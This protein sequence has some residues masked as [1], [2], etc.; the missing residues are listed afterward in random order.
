MIGQTLG[1]Y[2]LTA[3]LGAGGMGEV[4][5]A[6]DLRLGRDVALKLLPSTMAADP[7]ML[8]RFGQEARALAALDHPNIV[9]V[10]SVENAGGLHFL[11][12]GLV[13]GQTLDRLIPPDGLP[14]TKLLDLA[15]PL[16]EALA[17]AHARGIVHRDVKPGNVMVTTDGGLK[18]LDFGLSK[19]VS[20]ES[21]ARETGR[22]G[23]ET[24]AHTTPGTLLGTMPYMS[25]EQA[26]CLAV[27]ARSDIFSLG[28]VLYEMATGRRPFRGASAAALV[29]SILKDVPDSI[30]TQRKD[31]PAKF[32]TCVMHCLN[33]DRERRVQSLDEVRSILGSLRGVPE[34]VPVE[35]RRS[36][37]T[38]RPR[39]ENERSVAVLPFVNHSADA[40]D[41]YFS[42]GITEEI[43]NA[44]MQIDGLRVAARTSSFAFKGSGKDLRS[45][46]ETLR[47]RNVLEGSVRRSG[48]RLRVTAQLVDTESG[49]HLWS[50]R[51]D[52]ELDDVF[53]IQ[54]EIASAIASKLEVTL[55]GPSQKPS[56]RG[57]SNLEAFD[58]YLRGLAL[59]NRRG[60]DLYQAIEC[61]EK[62]IALDPG[63]ADALA[64]MA[65]GHRLLATYGFERAPTAMPRARA[66]AERAL[67]LD[68]NHA[69]ALATLADIAGQYDRDPTKAFEY[70]DRALVLQNG[71]TRAR[72]ERAVWGVFVVQGEP[73]DAVA[74][75]RR[76][77]DA[78]PLNVW[79]M[80]MLTL[81]LGFAGRPG[82]GLEVA[83]QALETDP[84]SYLCQYAA[85]QSSIWAED[86]DAAIDRAASNLQPSGRHP[87]IL[88][89][90]GVAHAACG[91][92]ELADAVLA[93]LQAR[94]RLEYVQ[95]FWLAYLASVLGRPE[96]AVAWA[97]RAIEEY[98]PMALFVTRW[99]G[100]TETLRVH[101]DYPTLTRAL[102]ITVD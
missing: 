100:L 24:L 30:A 84:G 54:D 41:E 65:D 61:F 6:H 64:W 58:L 57:T 74:E 82:E 69:E 68:P 66:A 11:T 55:G 93:E 53:E 14:W 35:V 7:G 87:W 89:T 70:W 96:E 20:P 79:A 83:M 44:L 62:A 16:V 8:E 10:H 2:R 36:T 5:R 56:R 98:D 101:R 13:E 23:E 85:V 102:N 81:S 51:Y 3:A 31:L 97:K 34:A 86:W 46:A 77:V 48:R 42:D 92:S 18:V 95:P 12:M 60:R 88:G 15:I 72:C 25:P 63:Y 1:H 50:E 29:S 43:L 9:T 90:L 4:Y 19:S 40:Q 32:E 45:V 17:A 38:V 67:A 73:F 21:A 33:K 37:T 75:C 49:Y 26:E 71:H 99:P 78:D 94:V 52:R 47:V 76:A 91:N 27:D 59:Q 39:D 80:S 28:V 22:A